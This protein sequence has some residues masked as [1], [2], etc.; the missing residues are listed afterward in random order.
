MLFTHW[1]P[2]FAIRNVVVR[3]I[4]LISAGSLNVTPEDCYKKDRRQRNSCRVA[5][6]RKTNPKSIEEKTERNSMSPDNTGEGLTASQNLQIAPTDHRLHMAN[7]MNVQSPNL[8]TQPKPDRRTSRTKRP[9]E[10]SESSTTSI[11]PPADS[12]I[13]ALRST[14]IP[15]SKIQCS[16]VRTTEIVSPQALGIKLAKEPRIIKPSCKELSKQIEE[17]TPMLPVIRAILTMLEYDIV[18]LGEINLAKED[19]DMLPRIIQ[20]RCEQISSLGQEN[21][22]I[23]AFITNKTSGMSKMHKFIVKTFNNSKNSTMKDLARKSA[24]D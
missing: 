24:Q 12:S 23:R 17:C 11:V 14:T 22:K 6:E 18:G 4:Q 9:R 5:V 16:T 3:Y 13:R 19:N 7:Q 8:P 20:S 21:A 1:I 10:T 15:H 2:T